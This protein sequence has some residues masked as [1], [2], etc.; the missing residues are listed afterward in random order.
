MYDIEKSLTPIIQRIVG[1]LSTRMSNGSRLE[2]T[3][4][5]NK[6]LACI[7]RKIFREITGLGHGPFR[8]TEARRPK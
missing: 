5:A 7:Y 4:V 6:E 2:R 3:S 8:D 1:S